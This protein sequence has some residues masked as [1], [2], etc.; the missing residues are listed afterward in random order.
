MI[1]ELE[2]AN[3]QVIP[4]LYKYKERVKEE[5]DED[6]SEIAKEYKEGKMDPCREVAQF[7]KVRKIKK[8]VGKKKE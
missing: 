6:E 3:P 7:E 8:L 4:M 5:M 2:Y 1:K